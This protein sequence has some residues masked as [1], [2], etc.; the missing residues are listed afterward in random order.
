MAQKTGVKGKC[1]KCGEE[2]LIASKGRCW[3]CYVIWRKE[4]GQDK[5][6]VKRRKRRKNG[7]EKIIGAIN[8]GIANEIREISTAIHGVIDRHK[9]L[10]ESFMK[11]REELI[12]SRAALQELKKTVASASEK[13]RIQVPDVVKQEKPTS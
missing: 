7:E 9:T 10:R 4:T 3:K 13:G 1:I 11:L 8:F 2:K 5:K 6:P 12:H